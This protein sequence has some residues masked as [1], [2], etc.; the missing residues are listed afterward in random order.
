M[1]CIERALRRTIPRPTT[2][3]LPV[4]RI[5]SSTGILSCQRVFHSSPRHLLLEQCL[6]TTHTVITGLHS[7]TGLPWAATIPLTAAMIRLTI[8]GPIAAY[9]QVISQRRMKIFPLL[10]AWRV[11]ISRNI[12]KAHGAEGPVACEKRVEKAMR[13][14]GVEVRKKMGVQYWKSSLTWI[15]L[16]IFLV[17]IDTIRAMS[18]YGRG[19]LGMISGLFSREDMTLTEAVGEDPA[20]TGALEATSPY[21]EAS[22]ASEGAWWFP[23]LLVPDPM[24]ILPFTLSASLFATIFALEKRAERSAIPVGKWQGRI[25][26]TMKVFALL[27]GP[28]TLGV[29]SGM[30]LY[31]ISTSL[32]GL[33]QHVFL[34]WY[35]PTKPAIVPCRP[36]GMNRPPIGGG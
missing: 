3:L 33:C 28:A 6:E 4:I 14:K 21:F 19:L 23:N 5:K 13:E 1:P 32:C 26:Q 18:G 25:K 12:M 17:V 11:A 27:I 10:Y 16:P 31:W 8:I 29:P 35:F 9:G 36:K 34:D 24:L 15:Q 2:P 30:L 20:T 22:L 7:A